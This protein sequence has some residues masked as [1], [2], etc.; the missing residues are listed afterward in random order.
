MTSFVLNLSGSLSRI[1]LNTPFTTSIS[2]LILIKFIFKGELL[3]TSNRYSK[4]FTNC[5]NFSLTTLEMN[6]FVVP[7]DTSSLLS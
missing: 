3:F 4:C 6:T 7:I 1:K 5:V 2:S